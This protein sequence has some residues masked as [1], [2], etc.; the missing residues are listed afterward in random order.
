[1]HWKCLFCFVGVEFSGCSVPA[2]PPSRASSSAMF[3]INCGWGRQGELICSEFSGCS[4][5]DLPPSRA[6]SS[7]TF[8]INCG[9]GRQGELTPSEFSGR[10]VPALPPELV[11]PPR[12]L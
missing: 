8:I 10:S 5:P 4:V 2:L 3:I 11:L 9:W 7:T 12:L 1:M 6:S